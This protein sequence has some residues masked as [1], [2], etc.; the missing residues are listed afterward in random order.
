MTAGA[1]AV[2]P[3]YSTYVAPPAA[4]DTTPPTYPETYYLPDGTWTVV[5]DAAAAAALIA[6][7]P[8]WSTTDPR[9]TI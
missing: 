4:P 7:N 8:A 1:T 6:S 5:V 9:P 2:S 3:D